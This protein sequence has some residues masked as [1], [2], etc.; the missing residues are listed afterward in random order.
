LVISSGCGQPR[1]ERV[2][3]ALP[4]ADFSPRSRAS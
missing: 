3:R 2:V 4:D 1:F